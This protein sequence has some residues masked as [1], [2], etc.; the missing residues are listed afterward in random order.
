[1]SEV[2]PRHFIQIEKPELV[3]FKIARESPEDV[4]AMGS[5]I[6]GSVV[7]PAVW[8]RAPI[9]LDSKESLPSARAIDSSQHPN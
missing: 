4:K 6:N 9:S 7:I 2:S 1:M 8:G 5:A 3:I